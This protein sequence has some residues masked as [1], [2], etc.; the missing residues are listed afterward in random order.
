R[1]TERFSRLRS[2]SRSPAPTTRG[3]AMTTALTGVEFDVRP[4]MLLGRPAATPPPA[5]T[6]TRPE[7][8]Q[9]LRADV[10]IVLSRAHPEDRGAIQQ[11]ID[12]VT[13][14]V[15][16]WNLEHRLLMPGGVVMDVTAATD[17]R[18][19]L[20]NAYAE[21]H[22]L[23]ERL[24]SENIVRREEIDTPS[25]FEEIVGSSPPLRAVLSNVSRVAPT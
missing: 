18:R 22:A 9:G 16:D 11:L 4:T 12:R 24:Q 25:M 14:E 2:A 10:Q 21:I 19:A 17:S 7:H 8:A 6:V 23:K 15:E 3:A 5:A 20:E 1:L 13:R